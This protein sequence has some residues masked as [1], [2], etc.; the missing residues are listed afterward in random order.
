MTDHARLIVLIVAV[1]TVALT[2]CLGEPGAD[3]PTS[4]ADAEDMVPEGKVV[5]PGA[6]LTT[7]HGTFTVV[8]YPE[9]APATVA[10]FTELA[11]TGWY[12]GTVFDRTV[13]NFVIQGGAPQEGQDPAD[14]LPLEPGGYFAA[15]TLGIARDV[16]P[17]SGTSVFFVCEY[18][19]PHLRDPVQEGSAAGTAYGNFTAFAQVIEGMD[20]VRT[21]AALAHE[22]PG[23]ETPRD[24]PPMNVTATQVL[25]DESVARELPLRTWSRED[26]GAYRVSMDGPGSAIAQEPSW[27]RV[28]I[29]P[30][31]GMPIDLEPEVTYS[32]TGPEGQ[33]VELSARVHPSD[34]NITQ[35]TVT[36][37]EPGTYTLTITDRNVPVASYDIVVQAGPEDQSR[38]SNVR[39]P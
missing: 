38:Q 30:R 16:E 23:S 4:G 29:E 31:E 22:N 11:R 8:F 26:V 27:L 14:P 13:D 36:Y 10:Q 33:A 39:A 34:G 6:T 28:Y 2:G 17:D 5:L 7:P 24:P 18:P 9:L 19:Q 32:L 1:L 35:L 20:V 21:I 15:G 12:N 37:P 3:P 25:L